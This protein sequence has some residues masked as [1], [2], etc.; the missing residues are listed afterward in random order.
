MFEIGAGFRENKLI[1]IICCLWIKHLKC[2][3]GINKKQLIFFNDFAHGLK[4]YYLS[5]FL[6]YYYYF[7]FELHNFLALDLKMHNL[8]L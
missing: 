3:L 1:Y 7:L 2:H 6:I 4:N 8:L 5:S